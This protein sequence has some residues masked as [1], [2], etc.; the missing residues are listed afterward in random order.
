MKTLASWGPVRTKGL[1]RE[2][3]LGLRKLTRASTL[4]SECHYPFLRPVMHLTPP[5]RCSA[6][7]P[8]LVG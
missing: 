2:T 3:E 4:H 1:P 7:M 6:P 5:R 8:L